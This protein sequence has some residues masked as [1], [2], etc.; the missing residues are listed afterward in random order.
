MTLAQQILRF[1][2]PEVEKE[3]MEMREALA[4][5]TAEAEDVTRTVSLDADALREWIAKQVQTPSEIHEQV[6][7][8]T[9]ADICEFRYSPKD[10]LMLI[11]KHPEHEAHKSG[12]AACRASLCPK[13]KA[14][15]K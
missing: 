3:R 1:V 8:S 14:A 9:F 12:I 15:Q 4:R 10:S 5:A 7:F 6:Q 2:H 11:C 13:M